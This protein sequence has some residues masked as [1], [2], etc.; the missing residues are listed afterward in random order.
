MRRASNLAHARPVLQVA[1]ERREAGAD[2]RALQVARE[3]VAVAR[4]PVADHRPAHQHA[5]HVAL[6]ERRLEVVLGGALEARE[7]PL[8]QVLLVE[9][10]DEHALVGARRRHDGR[11]RGLRHRGSGPPHGRHGRALDAVD[12]LDRLRLAVLQHLEVVGREVGDEPAL[13][14]GDD[15]VHLD[16]DRGAVE[17]LGGGCGRRRLLRARGQERRAGGEEKDDTRA[18]DGTLR[19]DGSFAVQPRS[20]TWATRYFLVAC[21]SRSMAALALALSGP[22]CFRYAS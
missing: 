10:E 3:L 14:V 21:F 15:G 13:A 18:D 7:G 22:P 9:E 11:R 5:A 17:G 20:K 19:H 16:D 1:P 8:R 4:Q 2:L 12:G 6:A